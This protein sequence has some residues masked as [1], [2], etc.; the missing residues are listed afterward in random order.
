[1][2]LGR[3]CGS[4]FTKFFMITP[5]SKQPPAKLRTEAHAGCLQGQLAFLPLTKVN[6]PHL[7]ENVSVARSKPGV[8]QGPKSCFL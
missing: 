8:P 3:F 1:M 2:G 4:F 6:A 5:K 7:M